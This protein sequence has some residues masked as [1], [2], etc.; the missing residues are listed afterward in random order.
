MSFYH[1]K[2]QSDPVLLLA[3]S[4]SLAHLPS[5]QPH[6]DVILVLL[7]TKLRL[8]EVLSQ[9]VAEPELKPRTPW[10]GVGV[11]EMKMT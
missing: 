9:K 2:T 10:K 8:R 3:S 7:K 5:Q 4:L 11:K 1:S 6:E